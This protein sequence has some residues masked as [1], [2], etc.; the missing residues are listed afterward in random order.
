ML[1]KNYLDH[2]TL[3]DILTFPYQENDK[4]VSGDIFISID[5]V[6]ENATEFGQDFEKEVKRVMVH[7]VLH[8]IGY[9]DHRKKEKVIMTDRED[10]YLALF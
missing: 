2:E 9:S 7:G 6:R 3:T 10:Y 5:R 4:M 8:L 1:N